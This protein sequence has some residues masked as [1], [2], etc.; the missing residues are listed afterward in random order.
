LL[1][2]DFD[3]IRSENLLTVIW[4]HRRVEWCVLSYASICCDLVEVI[5]YYWWLVVK[6]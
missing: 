1:R 5:L 4:L 3:A 6:I 2:L